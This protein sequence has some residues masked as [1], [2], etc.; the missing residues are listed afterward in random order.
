LI[1][2]ENDLTDV[3]VP[4]F[5]YKSIISP[6]ETAVQSPTNGIKK[7]YFEGTDSFGML[8]HYSGN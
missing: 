8:K 4:P 7:F 2:L 3:G 6:V 5:L 1:I